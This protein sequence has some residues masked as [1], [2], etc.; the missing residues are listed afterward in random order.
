[1]HIYKTPHIAPHL[2]KNSLRHP[3]S[4]YMRVPIQL[5]FQLARRFSNS[6]FKFLQQSR[7]YTI[8]SHRTSTSTF[9]IHINRTPNLKTARFASAARTPPATYNTHNTHSTKNPTLQFRSHLHNILRS[10]LRHIRV[11]TPPQLCNL[12]STS[13]M[14]S[15]LYT[16]E[17]PEPI[18]SSKGLHLITQSTP[19]GQKV[20]I[21]LEELKAI[22]GTEWGTS[23]INIG[24]NEQKKDWFLRLN[25]NGRIPVIIDNDKSFSVMETSAELLYL[26]DREDRD[27]HFD[28][29]DPLEKSQLLQWLYF[30]HGSGAPYQ[31]Q[32][33]HFFK[34]APAPPDQLQYAQTR[35][36][37]ET[38]R[39]FGVI[40]IHLSGKYTGQPREYLAGNGAGKYSVA[41]IGTWP[42]IKG[43]NFSGA[44]TNEDME[45]FPHLLK[46]IDRISERP[47]VKLGTGDNYNAAKRPELYVGEKR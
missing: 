30:W 10:R 40:E 22:Y 9:N 26:V 31:G 28:F 16:D 20:Q 21:L 39:V 17:T 18:R 46:W 13:K 1:M 3:H 29:T 47:A 12:S 24:T 23:I 45:T 27:H 5:R 2:G 7:H 37:N 11:S 43:W 25:P 15:N 32:V 38:L 34:F 19:N 8:T 44:I 41:D 33:N 4:I 42:W 6:D 35:F 14:A 36:R